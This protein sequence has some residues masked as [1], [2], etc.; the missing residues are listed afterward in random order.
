MAQFKLIMTV[1]ELLMYT[2]HSI[3]FFL[4]CATG[5]K[6]RQQFFDLFRC[7]QHPDRALAHNLHTATSH[8][9][10]KTSQTVMVV[11]GSSELT[12]VNRA[13]GIQSDSGSSSEG[14][15]SKK[16]EENLL[17]R[18]CRL[19]VSPN[20]ACASDA[21]SEDL[22]AVDSTGTGYTLPSCNGH[23]EHSIFKIPE[24]TG[25]SVK[26]SNKFN[27]TFM[28][29]PGYKVSGGFYNRTHDAPGTNFQ[30]CS[31]RERNTSAR[32]SPCKIYQSR[33]NHR[34]LDKSKHRNVGS[35]NKVNSKGNEY[36]LL[37]PSM[38]WHN[39][40]TLS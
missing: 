17:L 22:D 34:H 2:N 4:Y 21:S 14:S 12:Q 25:I 15:G 3:N 28:T 18:D 16:R 23:S 5:N 33:K 37:K 27:N 9:M 39:S 13:A 30:N 29:Y 24:N 1:T 40:V 6:F 35:G 38:H 11:L 7:L 20:K 19:T 32:V 10:R 36:F 8:S 31:H 26:D